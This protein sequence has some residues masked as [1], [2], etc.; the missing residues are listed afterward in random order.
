MK[1]TLKD[2]PGCVSGLLLPFPQDWVAITEGG[3]LH[4]DMN[5]EENTVIT[6]L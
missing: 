5:E 1:G 6:M 2:I 4:K 3:R